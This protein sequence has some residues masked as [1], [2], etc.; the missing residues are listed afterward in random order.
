MPNW[1]I[2]S[3]CCEPFGFSNSSAGPPDLT[4]RSTISV[5]SRSGSTSAEMRRS[6][7]SRSRSAIQSRRSRGG[8]P[9]RDQSRYGSAN[10]RQPR[11]PTVPFPHAIRDRN[12]LVDLSSAAR[13]TPRL[14]V[15]PCSVDFE[16]RPHLLVKL[17]RLHR[18]STSIGG[19]FERA[20]IAA[21][22]RK[23]ATAS[24]PSRSS[25]RS[26]RRTQRRRGLRTADEIA[27]ASAPCR[28]RRVRGS[29]RVTNRVR[30]PLRGR[31]SR[32][33]RSHKSCA[34]AYF[35]C[36][37]AIIGESPKCARLRVS[38]LS[39]TNMSSR[40][41]LNSFAG[42]KFALLRDSQQDRA[43]PAESPRVRDARGRARDSP[44]RTPA[45]ASRSPLVHE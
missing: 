36:A 35:P 30:H 28:A 45:P 19:S 16:D 22:A 2:R 29:R 31:L 15:H 10:S 17:H 24:V 39:A 42:S 7:P 12:L 26:D 40:L 6:S 32:S 1:L 43:A 38:P 27:A 34:C 11:R 18:E 9:R 4:T 3:G 14:L 5:I 25:L 33:A 21:H 23:Q 44:R 37:M 20:R 13:L 41:T 8:A